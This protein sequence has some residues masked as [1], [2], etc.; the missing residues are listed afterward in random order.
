ML[1]VLGEGVLTNSTK[2]S[3]KIGMGPI[4]HLQ[5]VSSLERAIGFTLMS[6]FVASSRIV[7]LM[8]VK[9]VRY[10][11][12]LEGDQSTKKQSL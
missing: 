9:S 4:P 3:S 10:W 12:G 1:T 5:V 11:R 8:V 2:P 7:D 6:M